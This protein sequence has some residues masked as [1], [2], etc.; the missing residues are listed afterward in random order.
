MEIVRAAP[1][2][3]AD[4]RGVRRAIR[5]VRGRSGR[6]DDNRIYNTLA[7]RTITSAEAARGWVALDVDLSLY[8]GRNGSLHRPD[9]RKW[10]II[11]GT[12]VLAGSV[13][14]VYL[15]SPALMTDV[16]GAR[17]YLRRQTVALI[18]SSLRRFPHHG[19]EGPQEVG[20]AV[21]GADGIDR[22]ERI[23]IV[24]SPCSLQQS[25]QT[26]LAIEACNCSRVT[27]AEYTNARPDCRRESTPFL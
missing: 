23:G 20:A 10:Q 19:L 14:N 26:L 22:F 21:L 17:E 5:S 24:A 1:R 2:A 11:V 6:R 16:E 9:G 7:E 4:V 15:G 27:T 13:S 12:H 8:A 25:R 3:P 18:F